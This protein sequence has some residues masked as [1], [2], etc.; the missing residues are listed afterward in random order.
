MGNQKVE[1]IL[2]SL[3]LA[4]FVV[5]MLFASFEFILPV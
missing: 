3:G 2:I 1:E 5:L 4:L